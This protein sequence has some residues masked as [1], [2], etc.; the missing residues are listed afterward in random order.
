MMQDNIAKVLVKN[1]LPTKDAGE[2][3]LFACSWSSV[4][5][6]HDHLKGSFNYLLH[7]K[8]G[9]PILFIALELNCNLFL[10]VLFLKENV[11]WPDRVLVTGAMPPPCVRCW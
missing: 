4:V 11:N 8:K 10:R 9:V 7:H 5:N 6:I 2:C 3:V 1:N